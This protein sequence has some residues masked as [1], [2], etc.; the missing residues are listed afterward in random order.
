MTILKT[1]MLSVL[2][3]ALFSGVAMAAQPDPINL[4]DTTGT[5]WVQWNWEAGTGNVTDTYNVSRTYDNTTTWFNGTTNDYIK[6][7]GLSGEL[8][9]IVVFAYNTTYSELSSSVTDTVTVPMMF[10][11]VVNLIAAIIPVFTA[12]LDLIIGVF[13]LIIGLAFLGGLAVLING[14]FGRVLKFGGKK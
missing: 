12:I 7:T 3:L 13:P 1:L 4:T 9:T 2:M 8:V 6:W 10:S 14:I 5:G 11:T